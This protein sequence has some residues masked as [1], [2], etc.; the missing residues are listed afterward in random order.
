[1]CLFFSYKPFVLTSEDLGM[2]KKKKKKNVQ[3]KTKNKNTFIIIFLYKNINVNHM[4]TKNLK[5][6]E[7]RVIT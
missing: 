7:R 5:I 4:C 2:M 6:R 1:M 3:W